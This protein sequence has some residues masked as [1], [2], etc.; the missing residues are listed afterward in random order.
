VSYPVGVNED[1]ETSEPC[2]CSNC[3]KVQAV[4][5]SVLRALARST[6]PGAQ[7]VGDDARIIWNSALRDYPCRAELEGL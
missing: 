1:G 5:R 7:R 2:S 4:R 6:M 3:R